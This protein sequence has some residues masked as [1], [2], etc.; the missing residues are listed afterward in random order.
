M[1]ARENSRTL[2]K[3]QKAIVDQDAYIYTIAGTRNFK[4]GKKFSS[5]KN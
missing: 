2:M 5:E 3:T 4:S 1:E